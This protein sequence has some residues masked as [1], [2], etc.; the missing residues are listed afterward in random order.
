VTFSAIAR[1]GVDQPSRARVRF[2]LLELRGENMGKNNS[3]KI[4]VATALMLASMMLPSLRVLASDKH[5][6]DMPPPALKPGDMA[7]DFKMEYV[8]ASGEKEV[9][10]NQYRGKKNVVLAFYIF[11][12]TGG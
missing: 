10:L 1:I 5:K 11:A 3:K 2:C 6:A 4:L 8:D 7:P 9:T 12:F